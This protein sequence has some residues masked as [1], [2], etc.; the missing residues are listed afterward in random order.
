MRLLVDENLPLPL[1]DELSARG[2]DVV[3]VRR[4]FRGAPDTEILAFCQSEARTV[5]TQ[6]KGFGEL[7]FHRGQAIGVILVRADLRTA[8]IIALLIDLIGQ[9][10][11]WDRMFTVVSGPDRVRSTPLPS[12]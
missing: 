8:D 4:A 1:I 5:I 3:S 6:D 2:H 11:D 9:R 7:V 10:D 12:R